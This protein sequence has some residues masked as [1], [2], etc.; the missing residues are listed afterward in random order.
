MQCV[1]DNLHVHVLENVDVFHSSRFMQG[2]SARAASEH[3]Q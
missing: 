2:T 1:R 3:S